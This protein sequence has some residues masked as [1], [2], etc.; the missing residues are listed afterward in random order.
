MKPWK[1]D[2]KKKTDLD[3]WKKQPAMRDTDIYFQLSNQTSR[4]CLCLLSEL[5]H[6]QAAVCQSQAAFMMEC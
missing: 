3:M 5:P 1:D 6:H 2:K 4:L